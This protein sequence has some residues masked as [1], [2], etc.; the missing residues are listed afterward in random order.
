MITPIPQADTAMRYKPQKHKDLAQDAC[1]A[2]QN[3]LVMP[4]MCLAERQSTALEAVI[5]LFAPK[6]AS[7]A[8]FASASTQERPNKG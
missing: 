1:D 7:A 6:T 2:M 3:A 5:H 8:R 4:R